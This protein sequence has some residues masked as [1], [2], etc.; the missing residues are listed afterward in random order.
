[1][2]EH[3]CMLYAHRLEDGALAVYRSPI[4]REDDDLY[5]PVLELIADAEVVHRETVAD[6]GM[7]FGEAEVSLYRVTAEVAA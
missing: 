6:D 1:M 2:I 4:V 3:D 5:Q 7:A